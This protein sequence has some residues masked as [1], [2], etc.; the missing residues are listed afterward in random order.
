MTGKVNVS[1]I[2]C[3]DGSVIGVLELDNPAALNALSYSMIEQIYAQLVEWQSDN[4]VVAVLLHASGEKAFCAGGDI[5]AIY[6]AL[7]NKEQQFEA[8]FESME[9]FFSLEYRCDHLIHT[10]PKPII[11]W[12]QGYLMGGG[13]GLFMGASHRVAA[14]FTRFAMPEIK[15]GLYPD[16]GA[17]YFLNHLPKHLALFLSLTACQINA[18]D[19]KALGLCRWV[20]PA[21]EKAR[22]VGQLATVSWLAESDVAGKLDALIAGFDNQPAMDGLLMPHAEQIAQLCCGDLPEIIQAISAAEVDDKWFI[23]AQK[24]MQYGS[25]LSLC[26]CYQQLTQYQNLSLKECFDLEFNLTLR[27]GLEGDFREGVRALIID[28]TNQPNWIHNDVAEVTPQLLARF[29]SPI[30]C[31]EHVVS[32]GQLASATR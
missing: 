19:M 31:T 29:F 6:R 9:R 21:E 14:S 11:A 13:V 23:A 20:A 22:F 32:T 5:Q 7:A 17:T 18:A 26:I 15:I 1:Q 4:T 27:C 8:A 2:E 3:A 10:Y 25:P 12:G 24:N 28:K 16:V 30:E